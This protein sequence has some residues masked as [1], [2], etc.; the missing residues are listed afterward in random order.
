MYSQNQAGHLLF[1]VVAFGALKM[2]FFS[3]VF[4]TL[5]LSFIS[6]VINTINVSDWLYKKLTNFVVTV[7]R[8]FHVHSS[9]GTKILKTLKFALFGIV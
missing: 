8:K 5:Y 4:F 6:D 2:C 3:T 9:V 7:P 1:I